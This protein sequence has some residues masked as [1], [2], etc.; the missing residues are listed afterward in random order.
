M[1]DD[2]MSRTQVRVGVTPE[3]RVTDEARVT[4]ESRVAEAGERQMSHAT[5]S[6]ARSTAASN[7]ALSAHNRANRSAVGGSLPK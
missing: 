4:A 2:Q 5:A 6:R 3:A 1:R 7:F